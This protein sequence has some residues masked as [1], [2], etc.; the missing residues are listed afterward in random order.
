M[1][2]ASKARWFALI[3]TAVTSCIVAPT[4]QAVPALVIPPLA[5][6][7]PVFATLLD[8]DNDRLHR[9]LSRIQSAILLV[10]V[11]L[12]ILSVG[13]FYVPGLVAAI[14]GAAAGPSETFRS[15]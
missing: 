5:S 11:V 13:W 3:W 2:W 10:F 9:A 6:I 7:P 15:V 8:S 12:A 14:I 4:I 1:T